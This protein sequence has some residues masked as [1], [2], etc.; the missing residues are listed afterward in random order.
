MQHR[1][2]F[3]KMILS[4]SIGNPDNLAELFT[5]LGD[6]TRLRILLLIRDHELSVQEMAGKLQMTHSA[7]SHHLRIL[8]FHHLVKA[9]KE[10]RNVFY[11]LEDKCVWN[12]LESGEAH[13]G[14]NHSKEINAL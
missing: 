14:H 8:R 4:N 7:V 1:E 13:L 12:L 3:T 6:F 5:V 10:S 9:R 2:K 11:S